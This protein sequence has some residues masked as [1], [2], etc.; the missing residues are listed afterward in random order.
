MLYLLPIT[1]W[2]KYRS[3]FNKEITLVVFTCVIY[4]CYVRLV[5]TRIQKRNIPHWNLHVYPETGFKCKL[6]LLPYK[7]K[8]RLNAHVF[9]TRAK[10]NISAIVSI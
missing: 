6:Q 10:F 1:A 8:V 9:F 4:T 5:N 7:C 2:L 3:Q